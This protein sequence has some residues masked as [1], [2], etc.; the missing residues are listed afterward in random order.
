MISALEKN[1]EETWKEKEMKKMI[2]DFKNSGYDIDELH[3]IKSKALEHYNNP[4]TR[5]PSETI[6]FPV[7][8]FEG[9]NDFR[10]ILKDS[11]RDIKTLIGD[12][13]IV[14][15]IKKNRSIGNAVV[16]NKELCAKQIKLETQKCNA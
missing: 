9:L 8:F 10:K 13:R 12:T 14:V 2:N 5:N 16:K 15:A 6:T 1:S 3:R 7:H 4:T 11:E